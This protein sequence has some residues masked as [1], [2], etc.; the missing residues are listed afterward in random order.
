MKKDSDYSSEQAKRNPR[1]IRFSKD[2]ASLLVSRSN[3]KAGTYADLLATKNR[4]LLVYKE[5]EKTLTEYKK[6]GEKERESISR[7][8]SG[9][10]NHDMRHA[11]IN[12]K[13]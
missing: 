1:T 12:R 13:S 5:G 11:D 9:M 10:V 3:E 7:Y 2:F 6:L 4:S 8:Y